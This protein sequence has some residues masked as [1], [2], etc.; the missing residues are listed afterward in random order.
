MFFGFNKIK[1]YQKKQTNFILKQKY[2]KLKNVMF[3]NK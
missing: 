3:L 2:A 1:K